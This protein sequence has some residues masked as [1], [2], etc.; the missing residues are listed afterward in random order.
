MLR[1]KQVRNFEAFRAD[2]KGNAAY[3][4]THARTLAW[5]S[6]LDHPEHQDCEKFH[7]LLRRMIEPNPSERPTASEVANV[8]KA[9]MLPVGVEV[10]GECP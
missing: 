10:I 2:E 1:G 6:T 4:Q 7:Y 3:S 5:L 8:I 9:C